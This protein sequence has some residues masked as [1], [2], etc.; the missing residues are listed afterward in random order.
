[1]LDEDLEDDE[2]LTDLSKEKRQAISLEEEEEED[3]GDGSSSMKSLPCSVSL[4]RKV[5]EKNLPD[6]FPLPENFRYDV[7]LALK[8]KKMTRETTKSFYSAV[9][10]SMLSFKRY[11]TREEYTRVA[12]EIIRKYPFLK[13]RT[14]SPTVCSVY[15]FVH[16]V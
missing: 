3:D 6:P 8:S 11:P 12:V 9:A 15:T 4:K 10:N 2:E 1:M 7:E 14:G 5:S 13:P 16:F